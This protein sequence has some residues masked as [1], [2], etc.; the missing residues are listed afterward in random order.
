MD[1]VAQTMDVILS[2]IFFFALIKKIA[3][4]LQCI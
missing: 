4:G 1:Y 2:T 3:G